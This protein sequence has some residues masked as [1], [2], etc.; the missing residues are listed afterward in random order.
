MYIKNLHFYQQAIEAT[1][2][3]NNTQTFSLG[4]QVS[5]GHDQSKHSW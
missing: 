1:V 3:S 2:I 4:Y 5:L